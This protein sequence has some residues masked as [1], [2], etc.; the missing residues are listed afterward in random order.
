MQRVAALASPR[1]SPALALCRPLPLVLLCLAALPALAQSLQPE[2]EVEMPPPPPPQSLRAEAEVQTT[3]T[4]TNNSRYGQSSETNSDLVLDVAPRVRLQR[5]GARLSL[6]GEA[7]LHAVHYARGTLGSRLLPEGRFTLESEP[8]EEWVRLDANGAVEQT[9]SDAFSGRP[10]AGSSVNRA[11]YKRWRIAPAIDRRLSPS[12][13][14]LARSEH[15]W[16]RRSGDE[17][18]VTGSGRV[19]EQRQLLQLERDPLPL[20]GA[21]EYSREDSSYGDDK[22]SA[23]ELE[24]LRLVASYA[25]DT[26][27]VLGLV[28]GHERNAFAGNTEERDS[29][30][31]VRLQWRPSERTELRG[32]VERRFMGTGWNLDWQHRSPF[33]AIHLRSSRRPVAQS[34]WQTLGGGAGGE[35]APLLDAIL[36]T[37]YPDPLQRQALVQDIIAGLGLP[38]ELLKPIDLVAN[39]AQ[40]EQDNSVSIALLSRRTTVTASVFARKLERLRRTDDP[41]FDFVA[42]G[43]DNEQRGVGL[44]INRRLSRTVQAELAL[45][46]SKVV[47]LGL[48]EGSTSREKTLRASMHHNLSPKTDVTVGVRRYLLN[49]SLTGP[50]QETAGFLGLGHRF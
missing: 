15:S 17:A 3:V 10:D 11:T 31:G 7:G 2:A 48:L 36:T 13:S 9:A 26:E 40:L 5:R 35:V 47:G 1:R 18:V 42:G 28:A 23:L 29:I 46:W 37:R 33:V 25:F 45:S 19:Y 12:L 32:A 34:S 30:R 50:S 38:T 8:V 16:S 4:A 27:F 20:G 14:L 22:Q 44:N 39:Y 21:V 41:A 43:A 24:A 6:S 49:S